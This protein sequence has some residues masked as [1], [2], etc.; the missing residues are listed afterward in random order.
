M[1]GNQPMSPPDPPSF[2][3]PAS[4]PPPPPS[5]PPAA[6]SGSNKTLLL[7]L[8]YLGILALIPLLVEKDDSDVQWH[9][10]HGLILMATYMVVNTAM[11]LA[12]VPLGMSC[13][14]G[15]LFGCS[16]WIVILVIHIVCIMKA[17][18]GERFRLP[19]VSEFADKW[20]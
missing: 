17:I 19:V 6:D 20:D 4:T 9:A 15:P 7:I 3:P 2:T 18:K 5:E 1:E 8:S 16:S 13:T 11:T 12:L 14:V 10:K